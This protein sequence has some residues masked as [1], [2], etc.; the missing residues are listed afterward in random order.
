[1]SELLK[2]SSSYFLKKHKPIEDIYFWIQTY[3]YS[4]VDRQLLSTSHHYTDTRMNTIKLLLLT[5]SSR[6]HHFSRPGSLSGTATASQTYNNECLGDLPDMDTVSLGKIFNSCHTTHN[7]SLLLIIFIHV[8]ST[9]STLTTSRCHI[10]C[11]FNFDKVVTRLW[12][13]KVAPTVSA[14]FWPGR[15]QDCKWKPAVAGVVF[16]SRL[17]I[18]VPGPSHLKA[19]ERKEEKNPH[20]KHVF[21]RLMQRPRVRTISTFSWSFEPRHVPAPLLLFVRWVNCLHLLLSLV[22]FSLVV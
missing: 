7:T 13:T 4:D 5:S 12:H 9:H 3:F 17:V 21:P 1:M 10:N 14:H 15:P 20:P 22:Q 8:Q 18:R 2:C 19:I 16:W 6:R 11:I